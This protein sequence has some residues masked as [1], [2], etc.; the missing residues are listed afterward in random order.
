MPGEQKM[1][2]ILH[3]D[4]ESSF[5]ALTKAFLERENEDFCVD[6]ASSAEE[7]LE[8]LKSGNYDVV[9]SDYQM[10]M[11]DGIKFLQ[12][13]RKRENTI[14]F[15]I[16]TGRG[17][18][19]VAIEALNKGANR[20]LQKG[21]DVESMFGTLAYEIEDAV[22]KN[23]AGEALRESEERYRLLFNKGND[24]VFLHEMTVDGVPGKI[25]DV[26]DVV[27][28]LL[29]YTREELL[30]LSHLDLVAPEQMQRVP[31]L[32]DKLQANKNNLFEIVTV[33]KYGKRLVFEI[34]QHLFNLNG[35]PTVLAIAR[36]ITDRKQA[37]E[38]LRE[39]EAK[40]S[41]VVENSQDGIVIIQEGVLKFVNRSY[42]VLMGYTPEEVL[43]K[44]FVGM[45]AP[46]FRELTRK[47]Y[48]DRMAGKEPPNIYE[49]ALLRKDGGIIPVEL[50]A[51]IIDYA[52]GPT[53]LVF[54]REIADRK[55]AEE[56]LLES[57]EKYKA[58]VEHAPFG[59][60]IMNPDTSFEYFNPIFTKMFGYTLED[61]PD[62]KT[63]FDK[64]Y[65][66]EEYRKKVVT[67]W[68]E[69]IAK[70]FKTLDL[71]PRVFNVRCKDGQDKVIHFRTVLLADGRHF[72][73]Y[74]DITEHAKAEEALNEKER[75]QQILLD[76]VPVSL[77]HIDLNS[78]FVHVNE[79]LAKRYGKKPEDFIGK[80]T[81]ELFPEEAESFIEN[82]R[83]ILARGEPQIGE[84][85]KI[86]TPEDESW[87]RLDKIP[88]KDAEG[89]VTG[90]IGFELD[91]TERIQ[92]QKKLRT[93]ER[94]HQTILDTVS[95]GIFHI[96]AE[97]RFVHV[98][99]ALAERYGMTPQDFKGKTTR[100]LFPD[101]EDDY[102]RSDQE[103]LVRG[104]PQTGV[105]RDIK[106]SEGV[107]WVRLDKMPVK[108][109]DG[110]V[111][112]I[113]GFELDIT[114]RIE[115]QEELRNA[116]KKMQDIVEF[117]PD[118]TFV[119]DRD[120]K[121]IAWNR[122]IEEMTGIPKDD[123]I[124]KG[125]YEYALPFYGER[126]PLLTDLVFSGDKEIESRYAHV[127]KKGNTLFA[128]VYSPFMY[129]GKGA[130]L[131]GIATPLYDPVGNVVGAIESIRDITE[132]KQAEK[133]RDDLLKELEAKNREMG[134]F[135]YT[136][137]HDLRSPLVTIQGFTTMLQ[138]DI[139]QNERERAENDLKYIESAVTKMSAFLSDTL[140]LSR[141]GSIVNP[142]EDVPFGD[143]VKDALEQTAGDLNAH[144]IDVSVANDFPTVH[145]DRMRI[146]EVLVNFITNSIKYRGDQPQP[147]IEIG[148]RVAGN[149]TVFFVKDNGIGIDK[150]QYE[151]VFELFYQVDKGG[152]G[153]GAGLAI[154]KR[155]VEVHG[156]RIWIESEK[157]KGC[158]VCFTLPVR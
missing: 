116:H 149:E 114:T 110:N 136:V 131:W 4:D 103:V 48:T 138:K 119:I 81:R 55:R 9:L 14:P 31:T 139:E 89:N 61:L 120:M 58:I 37:D 20:Y 134:H 35:Q 6:I 145:V 112:G 102:V 18:E 75:E 16:F 92:T 27:C 83:E 151:K 158:T 59:I 82:D 54:I 152:E 90:I 104:E 24:A 13:L 129:G 107:R 33:T 124:G 65:P 40:Y 47:R 60:S 85:R 133:E 113:I 123:I 157:G 19:E 98:N 94:E 32:R 67:A 143:I 29:G 36:D 144:V 76:H 148:Y 126:R 125:D 105:M 127:G 106:T 155:I 101:K 15:I 7:G 93:Q 43:E 64:A 28:S 49:I 86:T 109:A 111:T 84:I 122:A 141:I 78:R 2:R 12:T 21:L 77:F 137:S 153:T 68:N 80:T 132:R 100:E 115:A 154:V 50:N 79:A 57:E 3:V 69:D 38:V 135:T 42:S 146:V 117:L 128:E 11:M 8:L 1:I 72:L 26:N 108:D 56:A 44:D 97:S 39:T 87:V 130:H 73:T 63:W 121:V 62:K 51:T 25:I 30:Q 156:G 70:N 46:E 140:E 17:R 142:P 45:I 71:K 118:A 41:A 53:D 88:F 91:I 99:K 95:V 66:D 150:S 34:N 96:D 52:G 22:T 23:R 5:L 74:Q 147:K 10:P